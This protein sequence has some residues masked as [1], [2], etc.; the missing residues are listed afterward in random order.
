[1][2]ETTESRR[3]QRRG[4]ETRRRLLQSTKSLLADHDYQSITL[5]QVADTVGVAKSSILW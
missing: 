3:K 1:M 5:D 4:S 2:P